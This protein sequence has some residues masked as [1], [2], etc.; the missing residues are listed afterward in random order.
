MLFRRVC[1]SLLGTLRLL[2]AS[3]TL[4]LLCRAV[5]PPNEDELYGAMLS[6][7][8]KRAEELPLLVRTGGRRLRWLHCWAALLLSACPLGLQQ[9]VAQVKNS[10]QHSTALQVQVN[11]DKGAGQL[12]TPD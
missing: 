2:L 1:E 11:N 9:F 7:K 5:D 10:P 4:C 3:F 8:V 12:L 6:A